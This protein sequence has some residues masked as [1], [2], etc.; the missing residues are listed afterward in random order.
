MLRKL[1]C[2]LSTT[3][4]LKGV[5]KKFIHHKDYVK[6]LK[7]VIGNITTIDGS[8]F[9]FET[10]NGF[11]LWFKIKSAQKKGTYKK[12]PKRGQV[13]GKD[14]YTNI[15]SFTD[16]YK[17]LSKNFTFKEYDVKT[18]Q[19][20]K[21]IIEDLRD[22]LDNLITAGDVQ[23]QCDCPA[24]IYYGYKYIGTQLDY[25]VR[26]SKEKRPPIIRNSKQQGTICKHLDITLKTIRQPKIKHVL[27][28]YLMD[29]FLSIE[30][31]RRYKTLRNLWWM[32]Y[33]KYIK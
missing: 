18:N 23:L 8:K 27:V 33:F 7:S 30:S 31:K 16:Y 4:I 9:S 28:E 32:D 10:I 26:T 22:L 13:G 25:Q 11:T 24:Y 6:Q 2:E 20:K 14:Y 19:G 3:Q 29:K 21:K 5:D 12:K 1:Y 17:W 15:V